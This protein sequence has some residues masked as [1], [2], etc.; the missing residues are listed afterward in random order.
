MKH[1]EIDFRYF[2]ELFVLFYIG[3]ILHDYY[4][5]ALFL[6]IGMLCIWQK[7]WLVL[8]HYRKID[9]AIEPRKK[10]IFK[11]AM[12]KFFLTLSV[13][14]IYPMV[15]IGINLLYFEIFN[16]EIIPMIDNF[17]VIAIVNIFQVFHH[18][19]ELVAVDR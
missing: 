1:K 17:I 6:L 4:L 11:K 13:L 15:L 10:A 12:T 14:S 9:V 7:I 2:L 16:K 19:F 18:Y 5:K 3:Y 8:F